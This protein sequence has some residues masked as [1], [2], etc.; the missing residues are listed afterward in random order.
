MKRMNATYEKF[1]IVINSDKEIL[2]TITDG[3]IRRFLI[4]GNSIQEKLKMY[5]Q[6]T[7]IGKTFENSKNF[8]KINKGYISAFLPIIGKSK[9]PQ[10]YCCFRV[11]EI[12]SAMIMAEDLLRLEI[13]QN[14]QS[15]A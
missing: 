1:Q 9:N 6:K 8:S 7:P 5:R 3:D 2:G 10:Y 13:L 14:T 12:N 11:P 15:L 4:K